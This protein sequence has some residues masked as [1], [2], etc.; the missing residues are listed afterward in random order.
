MIALVDCNNFY[1]SCERTLDPSLA[2]RPVAVLSN[3]DGVIISRS[4]EVKAL[5]VPM[6]APVHQYRD[7]LKRHNVALISA[8]F[9][10]YIT[11]SDA[12]MSVVRE[13]SPEI[14]VYSVDEAFL[15]LDGLEWKGL[16]AYMKQMLEHIRREVEIPVSVGIAQ[17]K[18]LAKAASELV[19]KDPASEGVGELGDRESVLAA[20]RQL[21]VGDVWGIGPSATA[22]L[23]AHHIH[24]AFDLMKAPEHWIRRHLHVTG[25]RTLM[26]L[27]GVRCIGIETKREPPKSVMRSRSFG[28][29][30][31]EL[32][33]MREAVAFFASIVG[34]TLRAE[35]CTARRL[36]LFFSTNRYN[37]DPKYNA[38]L[39][40]IL[41]EPTASS[42]ILIAHSLDM[43]QASWRDGFRYIKAGVVATEI[44]PAASL[45]LEL[46]HSERAERTLRVMTAVDTINSKYR[47]NLVSM[48]SQGTSFPWR[49][50]QEHLSEAP[51]EYVRPVQR[52]RFMP[53]IPIST[54]KGVL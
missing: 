35:G 9:G 46:G 42:Q 16:T 15:S 33:E 1:V 49:S 44:R 26:E 2:S 7:V 13:Y 14:E 31:T 19:K 43:L 30:I 54:G 34:E 4:N 11:I 39:T 45:Q 36:G 5:G 22:F 38:S 41:P 32:G 20:L 40:T 29:Y 6:A 21:P 18:T 52:Y 53:Y 3:N 25:L 50:K 27:R 17:T 10:Y 12:V 47:H 37:K 24:T 23:T 8:N 28:R 48:A 51:L